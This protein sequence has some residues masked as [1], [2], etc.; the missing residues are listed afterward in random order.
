MIRSTAD[1]VASVVA[2]LSATALAGWLAAFL[3]LLPVVPNTAGVIITG[4]AVVFGGLTFLVARRSFG[5]RVGGI[6]TLTTAVKDAARLPRGQL[7]SLSEVI[8][9][10]ATT[11]SMYELRE[12]AASLESLIAAVDERGERQAAWTA[13][14]AHDLKTP[15]AACANALA[16]FVARAEQREWG[17]GQSLD[18]VRSA[19]R[20]LRELIDAIQRLLDAVR[21][22]RD[23][24]PLQR[25]TV[26]LRA[27]VDRIVERH[28]G[29][30]PVRIDT[31]GLGSASADAT[32]LERALDNL[33]ANAVRY[34]RSSVVIEVFP[35]LVRVSDDGPGLPEPMSA[36]VEPFR[37]GAV[38]IE[39]M[40]ARA[41]AGGI[42]LFVAA[43]VLGIHGGRLT[44]ESTSGSGTVLL[45]Y[46]GS[47]RAA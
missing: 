29:T 25:S 43:R 13:A 42:G 10:M 35:G 18:L 27:L 7:S 22:E 12:L 31:S 33:I 41:G 4:A 1:D 14:A 15:V 20:E 40:G 23:D 36:L 45:A 21:F 17:L 3:V 8:R 5:R 37:S 19:E 38:T 44:V 30:S 2:V 39:G 11:A 26:D 32:L 34:A 46:I 6:R 47:Q 16:V 28:R 9:P 24:L